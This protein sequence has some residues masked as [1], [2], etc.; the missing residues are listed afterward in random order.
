MECKYKE[1]KLELDEDVSKLQ[2]EIEELKKIN[3]LIKEN[4]YYNLLAGKT[5]LMG[6]EKTENARSRKKHSDNIVLPSKRFIKL[7]Y[8]MVVDDELKDT[9]IYNLNLERDLLYTQIVALAHDLGHTPFGHLGERI[10][11]HKL[12]KINISEEHLN[13]ILQKKKELYGEEYEMQQGHIQGKTKRISFEHNEQSAKLFYEFCKQSQIDTNKIDLQ[14]IISSILA[15]S[16]SRVKQEYIPKDVVSQIV[17]QIDKLEEYTTNDFDEI[18]ELIDLER[19][20]DKSLRDFLKLPKSEKV[21]IFLQNLLQ[22]TLEK[23]YINDEMDSLEN[24]RKMKKI[25]F[26]NIFIMDS[27]GKKGLLTGENEERI[28]LMLEKIID[29]YMQNPQEVPDITFY[30]SKPIEDDIESQRLSLRVTRSNDSVPEEKVIDYICSMDNE[31]VERT[32]YRLVKKRILEGKGNGVEP[33]TPDEIEEKKH[34]TFEKEINVIKL[35]ELEEGVDHSREE[36]ETKLVQEIQ[37]KKDN[38]LTENARQRMVEVRKRHQ[39]ENQK[40]IELCN[41][42]SK[43]DDNQNGLRDKAKAKIHSEKVKK[44]NQN[45]EEQYPTD[46]IR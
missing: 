14:R 12:Q 1:Y 38:I 37:Y 10:I 39:E 44:I 5:Q 30:E 24:N 43:Y 29:Y 36:C 28:S 45:P 20:E 33:I 34:E 32:Y 26:K 23:G 7:L 6:K 11:N 2:E 19:I 25:H 9:D 16:T 4:A 18:K 8:E 41:L 40:D 22:E 17:R 3:D 21:K 46:G 31:K 13:R 35:Q 42:L 15:H 27:D